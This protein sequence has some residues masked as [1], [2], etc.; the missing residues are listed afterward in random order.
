MPWNRQGIYGVAI[1]DRREIVFDAATLLAVLACSGQMVEAIGL[2]SAPPKSVHFD[3]KANN[4]VLLYG[5]TGVSVPVESGP[6]G[7][8]LI[9]YCMRAGIKV[10]RH[11]SRAMRVEQHAIV[12]VFSTIH[13]VPSARLAPER[14]EE[15]PRSMSWMDARRPSAGVNSRRSF[16]GS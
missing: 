11:G 2:P 14:T 6:L 12:L 13:Q 8:L 10:P 1:I 5:A 15:M 7:A 16:R 3:P 4:I 9:A